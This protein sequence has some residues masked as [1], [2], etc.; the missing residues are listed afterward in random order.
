MT[1]MLNVPILPVVMNVNVSR[2]L[3]GMDLH[4]RVFVL[5]TDLYA[6]R[7]NYAAGL[8]FSTSTINGD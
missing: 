6:T 4:V 1:S 8:G 5:N 7:M 2:L 3:Q